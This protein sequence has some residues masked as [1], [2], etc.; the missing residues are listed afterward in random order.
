GLSSHPQHQLAARQMRGFGAV[1]N[2]E[3]DDAD[4]ADNACEQ[5][6]VI[7]HATSVGGV[8]ST[9]E[10][11][12]KLPGQEHVP[13]AMLRLSV[14]CEHIEDLWTDLTTVLDTVAGKASR[15]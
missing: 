2:F 10:R 1:L 4:T 14:G 11:R 12:A 13:P 5:L 15:P 8:E 7:S 3:L 6:K 9:I